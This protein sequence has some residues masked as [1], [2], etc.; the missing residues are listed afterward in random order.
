[1]FEDDETPSAGL[2]GV[3]A[4]QAGGGGVAGVVVSRAPLVA[5]R[6][7][8]IARDFG[9]PTTGFVVV[10]AD[11]DGALRI[12]FFSPRQEMDACGYVTLAAATAL[13]D[14]GRWAAPGTGTLTAL[15]GRYVLT[16]GADAVRLDVPI[17]GAS[18]RRRRR[19]PRDRRGTGTAPRMGRPSVLRTT[20]RPDRVVGVVGAARS[21]LTDHLH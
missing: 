8:A 21:V 14:A 18:G 10:D 2:Y 15:G 13:R 11:A 4:E 17:H 6:M 3:F 5:E 7:Q 12:R 1:M 19:P 9:A 16:L 20:I